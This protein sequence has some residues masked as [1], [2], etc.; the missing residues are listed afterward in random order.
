ML[1][2][3]I[4]GGRLTVMNRDATIRANGA[5]ERFELADRGA[6]RRLLRDTCGFDFPEVEAMRVPSAPD[7]G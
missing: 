3:M 4:P 5:T 2:A 1:R 7:W 6:L